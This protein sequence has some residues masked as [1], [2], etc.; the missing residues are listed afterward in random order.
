MP[1]ARRPTPLHNGD[2]RRATVQQVEA[3]FDYVR[4][5]QR[6]SQWRGSHTVPAALAGWLESRPNEPVGSDGRRPFAAVRAEL[7]ALVDQLDM[8][9]VDK[10][11]VESWYG[12]CRF[13][14]DLSG[15]QS[16][17]GSAFASQRRH[18]NHPLTARSVQMRRANAMAKIAAA[19]PIRSAREAI[20][21]RALK[22][23]WNEP[24]CQPLR[25]FDLNRAFDL[26]RDVLAVG[27]VD[28][29]RSRTNSLHAQLDELA[30]RIEHGLDH[31]PEK[32]APANAALGIGLWTWLA[33]DLPRPSQQSIFPAG[34]SATPYRSAAPGPVLDR[35]PPEAASLLR[36]NRDDYSLLAAVDAATSSSTA[37]TIAWPILEICLTE[38]IAPLRRPDHVVVDVLYRACR[39]ARNPKTGAPSLWRVGSSE[40]TP[41]VLTPSMH[42]LMPVLPLAHIDGS[43][44]PS[45]PWL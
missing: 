22:A 3:L 42:A 26:A 9:A 40:I 43:S 35:A 23:A 34:L 4:R 5:S 27:S 14:S 30:S 29:T 24:W 31:V 16:A 41:R 10:T 12:L 17:L 2:V 7:G 19:I 36:G 18:R 45:E 37:S 6:L 13:P 20:A 38:A 28:E 8:P 1:T 32:L 11:I 44:L 25:T 21:Y 33:P 39:Y 15:T